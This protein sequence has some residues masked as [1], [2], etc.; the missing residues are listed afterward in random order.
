MSRIDY[1]K[2]ASAQQFD[3]DLI[4]LINNNTTLIHLKQVNMQTTDTQIFCNVF[5]IEWEFEK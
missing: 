4:N 2:L 1:D 3:I 5:T